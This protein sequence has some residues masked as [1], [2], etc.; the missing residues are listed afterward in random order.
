[1]TEERKSRKISRS[2]PPGASVRFNPSKDD[3]KKYICD[4]HWEFGGWDVV[5]LV[6]FPVESDWDE[7]YPWARG[8][9]EILEYLAE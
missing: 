3:P 1:V 7:K 6:W 8:R 2:S 4:F 9:K 5:A